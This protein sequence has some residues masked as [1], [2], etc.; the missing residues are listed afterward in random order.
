MK[1]IT[2]DDIQPYI[3]SLTELHSKLNYAID[4]AADHSPEYKSLNRLLGL[5]RMTAMELLDLQ[6]IIKQKE[7]KSYE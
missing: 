5:T 3:L 6:S 7:R 2:A 1:W 4:M